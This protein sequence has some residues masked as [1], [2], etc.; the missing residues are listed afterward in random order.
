MLTFVTN[1]VMTQLKS[2]LLCRVYHLQFCFDF[3]TYKLYEYIVHI[4]IF[5]WILCCR[6]TVSIRAV[7]QPEI[8]I[9]QRR[10]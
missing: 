9:G 10:I 4:N 8:C 6:P 1:M 2:I 3:Y 5:C 7:A